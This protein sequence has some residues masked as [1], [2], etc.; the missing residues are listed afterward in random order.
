MKLLKHLSSY[1]LGALIVLSPMVALAAST[2]VATSAAGS[3]GSKFYQVSSIDSTLGATFTV[4]NGVTVLYVTGCG[5]GG[6]GAGGF[7]NV[8]GGGG[9]GGGSG[10]CLDEAPIAVTAGLVLTP[11]I[12]LAGLG[13][14][15]TAAGGVVSTNTTLAGLPIGTLTIQGATTAATAGATSNGGNGGGILS[16]ATGGAGGTT[17][18]NGTAPIAVS[19]RP[20]G[21]KT[22]Q[23]CAGAGGGS[24]SFS[25]AASLVMS[26]YQTAGA[27]GGAVSTTTGGGGAGGSGPWGV[28]GAGGSNADGTASTIGYGAGGGGGSGN[29]HAGANGT[30]GFLTIRYWVP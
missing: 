10:E 24:A 21:G 15:T 6:G 3:P 18:G 13:G 29:S 2:S 28:G 5:G 12:G 8:V 4:P 22:L 9:G 7:N 14:A 26:Q 1:L 27:S 23:I 30:P 20:S 19:M 11:T 16:I 25:G 17:P